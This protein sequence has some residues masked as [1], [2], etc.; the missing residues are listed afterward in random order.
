[1]T[2]YGYE[3]KPGE[4]RLTGIH[5]VDRRCEKSGLTLKIMNHERGASLAAAADKDV[6]VGLYDNEGHLAAGWSL[7]RLL[8]CWSAKHNESVY[9]PASKSRCNDPDLEAAGHKFMVEFSDRVMWCRETSAEQLFGA[10][11]EGTLFLD[12]APKYCPGDASLNKRRSQWR[13]NDITVAAKDLY[14]D[15]RIVSLSDTHPLEASGCQGTL[16]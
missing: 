11:Y 6:H 13:V 1:M 16:L 8:N 4:F 15:V 3:A 14:T 9:V 10:L 7:E 12:P 5:R 2:T